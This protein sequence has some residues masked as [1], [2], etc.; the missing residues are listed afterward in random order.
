MQLGR[1]TGK[2]SCPAIRPTV[3]TR[4]GS[5]QA[6]RRSAWMGI[7]L[8][9]LE[10]SFGRLLACSALCIKTDPLAP[11]GPGARGFGATGRI[12]A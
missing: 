12:R 4:L 9:F 8:R 1:S 2:Q 6:G 10:P 3:G 7:R 11:S 5:G